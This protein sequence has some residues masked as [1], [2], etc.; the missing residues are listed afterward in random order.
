MPGSQ[1]QITKPRHDERLDNISDLLPE[2]QDT[3][4]YRR[5]KSK[6]GNGFRPRPF[7]PPVIKARTLLSGLIQVIQLKFSKEPAKR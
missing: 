6:L 1:A 5:E 3:S 7:V 2:N 4:T